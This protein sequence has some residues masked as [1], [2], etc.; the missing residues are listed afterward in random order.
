MTWD[1]VRRG[2]S[3]TV[4]GSSLTPEEAHLLMLDRARSRADVAGDGEEIS[5]LWRSEDGGR[6]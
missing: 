3:W 5:G 6:A 2:R 1:E 4:V